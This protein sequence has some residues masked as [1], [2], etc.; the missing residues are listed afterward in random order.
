MPDQS[1]ANLA[2]GFWGGGGGGGAHSLS[3]LRIICL[4]SVSFTLEDMGTS[5]LLPALGAGHLT[6]VL[7]AYGL[8]P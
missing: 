4:A 2:I 1:F 8:N 7:L 3:S 5:G 6:A